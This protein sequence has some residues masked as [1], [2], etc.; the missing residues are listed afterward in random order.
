MASY[1][2]NDCGS[3]WPRDF[4]EYQMA[5]QEG[6]IA[7]HRMVTCIV[8]DIGMGRLRRV[9]LE[10]KVK[11]GCIWVDEVGHHEVYD[12]EPQQDIE[13]AI[14]RACLAQGWQRVTRGDW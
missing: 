4:P 7:V 2:Y 9:E 12:I 3:G 5:S 6:D 13:D 1:A 11:L 10:G 14:N 8:T